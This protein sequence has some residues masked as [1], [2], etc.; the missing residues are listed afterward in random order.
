MGEIA[1]MILDGMLCEGCGVFIGDGDG[2]TR[3]CQACSQDNKQHNPLT[4]VRRVEQNED[5]MEI[6]ERAGFKVEVKN[7]G[8]HWIITKQ[9][10][11]DYW[12]SKD[13]F[14]VMNKGDTFFG[15]HKMMAALKN[16]SH[17]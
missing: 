3:S 10:R 6:L 4:S 14:R 16:R 5:E 1:E 17:S 7:N 8:Y 12:P 9:V 2:I 11:A 13:K 15:F